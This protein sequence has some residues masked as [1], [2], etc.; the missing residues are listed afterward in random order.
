MKDYSYFLNQDKF[1][2]GY[3]KN[4]NR[5]YIFLNN[6]KVGSI[7]YSKENERKIEKKMLA[8]FKSLEKN[9]VENIIKDKMNKSKQALKNSSLFFIFSVILFSCI[10]LLFNSTI[11]E[12]S[13]FFAIVFTG[14][15]T[16]ETFINKSKINSLY[17]DYEKMKYFYENRKKFESLN[18]DEKLKKE[19]TKI[20][21]K[22]LEK[23]NNLNEKI[24]IN[25]ISNFS[26]NELKKIKDYLEYIKAQKLKKELD[27]DSKKEILKKILKLGEK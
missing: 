13:I 18:K 25:T 3:K 27:Q 15:E 2:T 24:N 23:Y 16:I 9:N 14:L 10:T 1:I 12:L 8:Q 4:G 20:E 21:D 7:E 22:K 19:I 26:L 11:L 6:K 17:R 5:L